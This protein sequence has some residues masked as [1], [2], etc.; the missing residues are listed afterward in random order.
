MSAKRISYKGIPAKARKDVQKLRDFYMRIGAGKTPQQ[1][2]QDIVHN[3]TRKAKDEAMA[4][5]ERARRSA[6]E[7]RKSAIRALKPALGR[8]SLCGEIVRAIHDEHKGLSY[9][10]YH[11]MAGLVELAISDAG[12]KLEKALCDLGLVPEEDF[13]H[14]VVGLKSDGVKMEP[15]PEEEEAEES[16]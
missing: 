1:L 4:S 9:L 8:L 2:Y 14:F 16:E 5:E 11:D 10:D 6:E 12:A 15:I 7:V 3:Q 13:G